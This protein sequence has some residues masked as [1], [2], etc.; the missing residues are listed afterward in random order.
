MILT[1][2]SLILWADHH[3]LVPHWLERVGICSTSALAPIQALRLCET[4]FGAV[5]A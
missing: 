1:R 3:L 2:G 4:A 5:F